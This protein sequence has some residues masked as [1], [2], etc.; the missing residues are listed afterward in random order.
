MGVE[1]AGEFNHKIN[2]KRTTRVPESVFAERTKLHLLF[3][4]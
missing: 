1:I 3:A 2:T 4:Q